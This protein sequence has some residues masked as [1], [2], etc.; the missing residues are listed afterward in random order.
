MRTILLL[1]AFLSGV[2]AGCH[3]TARPTTL[4]APASPSSSMARPGASSCPTGSRDVFRY[5]GGE[6]TQA[7]LGF[8]GFLERHGMR[9]TLV[10]ESMVVM[11]HNDLLLMLFMDP[12]AQPDRVDRI[13]AAASFELKDGEAPGPALAKALHDLSDQYTSATFHVQGRNVIA[14]A[15]VTYMDVLPWKEFRAFLNWFEFALLRQGPTL[16]RFLK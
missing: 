14:R 13:V 5:S 15:T 4:A 2:F 8:K 12:S 7:A 10:K 11:Q 9:V 6:G 16:G 1:A 3:S